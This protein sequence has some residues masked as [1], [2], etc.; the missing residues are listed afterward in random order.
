VWGINEKGKRALAL[1]F[2]AACGE[3]LPTAT[4]AVGTSF[5]LDQKGSK[6]STAAFFSDPLRGRSLNRANLSLCDFEQRA[7]YLCEAAHFLGGSPL[8]NAK[9]VLFNL[10]VDWVYV[11]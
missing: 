1:I 7:L 2:F 6:K 8:Q 4:Y 11:E 3:C 10:T 5:L 9:P